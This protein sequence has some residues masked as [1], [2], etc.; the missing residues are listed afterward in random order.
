ME[1]GFGYEDIRNIIIQVEKSI[2]VRSQ[3]FKFSL[4]IM[5][6][7]SE[8]AKVAKSAKLITVQKW[9]TELNCKLEYGIINGKVEKLVCSTCKR[10]E[11][12]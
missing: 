4:L 12:R 2:L 10:W 5:A 9:E 7:N 1:Y 11:K 6:S 3:F 8:V